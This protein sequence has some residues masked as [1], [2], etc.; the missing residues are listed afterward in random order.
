[1]SA[2]VEML[3]WSKPD[4]DGV[5]TSTDRRRTRRLRR[6]EKK[7]TS[8]ISAWPAEW[9]ELAVAWLRAGGAS[10]LSKS[11]L[12]TSGNLRHL[13]YDAMEAL[14]VAGWIEL[15][16]EFS[17]SAWIPHRLTWI[18]A[19]ELRGLLGMR[20]ADV[21]KALRDVALAD[22][23]TDSRLLPLHV[24]LAARGTKVVLARV[25][26]IQRLDAWVAGKHSGTRQAFAQ[27][28]RGDSEVIS[29]DEWAWLAEHVD[30]KALGVSGHDAGIQEE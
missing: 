12:K 13:A 16:D 25:P 28:A 4:A 15:E 5:R 14:L 10:V 11:L 6:A 3:P 18:D 19:E 1:M 20:R 27:F 23:P 22:V 24:S 17:R 7:N 30:L 2:P 8:T 29:D 21:E 26:L 9:R